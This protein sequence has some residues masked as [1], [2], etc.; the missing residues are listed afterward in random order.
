[1]RTSVMVALNAASSTRSYVTQ[2]LGSVMLLLLLMMNLVFA[3]SRYSA[4]HIVSYCD[5]C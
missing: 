4:L 5:A 2:Y 3:M 1:M